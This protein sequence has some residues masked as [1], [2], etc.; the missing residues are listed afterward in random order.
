MATHTTAECP[1][2]Q[3]EQ[4]LVRPQSFLARTFTRMREI[5]TGG[6]HREESVLVVGPREWVEWQEIVARP[7][8]KKPGLQK[9]LAG[10]RRP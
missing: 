4:A 7:P 2:R 10:S 8:Q 1:S 5:F 3:A 9:L 6:T